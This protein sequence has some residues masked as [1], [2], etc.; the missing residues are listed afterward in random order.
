[1]PEENKD[2]MLNEFLPKVNGKSSVP[3]RLDD[4]NTNG[5]D[6]QIDEPQPINESG[7]A[8]SKRIADIIQKRQDFANQV[9][10]VYKHLSEL[11]EKIV[12]LKQ[13]R[14]ELVQK[15]G[16]TDVDKKLTEINFDILEERID[17]DIK[18][19][20]K[21]IQRF[22]RITLNIGVV[23]TMGQGKSE[24]LKSLS[25][26]TN[27]E[28]PAWKGKACTA[29]RSKVF[30]HD[31]ET[32]AIVKFHSETTF[33]KEVIG[34]YYRELNLGNIPTLD[35]FGSKPLPSLP[36]AKSATHQEMYN[37]LQNDYHLTFRHYH[38][39]LKTGSPREKII[40][41]KEDISKYVAQ[42][43]DEKKNL[44]NVEH[45][46]V[47]EVEIRCRFPKIEVNRLGLVD[48]PGLGDT[49][50]A[51]EKLI[52]KTLE[53]E[54]DI[55]LFV[56]KPDVDRYQWDKH[57]FNLY[58]IANEALDN[59]ASRA[60]MVL[61]YRKY[62]NEDNLSACE[63]LKNDTQS[64][65]IAEQ[66]IIADC[67]DRNETNKVLTKI[68]EYLDKNILEIE[69]QYARSRQNNVL[70]TYSY[71]NIELEK[72]QKALNSYVGKSQQ[73]ESNFEKTINA[74]STGLIDLLENLWENHEEI[75]VE[76]QK[77]IDDSIQKCNSDPGI[78]DAEQITELMRHP[79]YKN[80]NV[81]HRVLAAELRSHLSQNFLSLDQGLKD[82]SD[83]LKISI[84][85]TL[86]T[87][88]GL[89]ELAKSLDV[90]GI[91]FLEE[92][93]KM[94]NEH[95]NKLEVGFKTLLEFKM[96]Y[97]A[98]ILESIRRELEQVLGGVRANSQTQSSR[99][100]VIQSGT[101]A[102]KNVAVD[103]AVSVTQ[104]QLGLS[105][106]IVGEVVDVVS[107]VVNAGANDFKITDAASVKSD[108]E[109]LHTEAVERCRA[110]LEE[111]KKTPSRV[112][113]YMAEEFIDRV[114]YDK[115]MEREWRL[116]LSDP[117]ITSKVWIEFKQIEERKQIQVD[118][119]SAVK[120]VK[121]FNQRQRLVF[122]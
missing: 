50:V 38:N 8:I 109:R 31:G 28:L 103:V 6:T 71:I 114:L 122:V 5:L 35:D 57:D 16:S 99:E 82:A 53:Q 36:T 12:S 10:P 60:F 105:D 46:A 101:E 41:K 40:T 67:S 75:D 59:L 80:L 65:I 45:L 70:Q 97:G 43:R 32:K 119:I 4:P 94:L 18:E 98:L 89:G 22:S 86:I 48:V 56:R 104:A 74:L 55:V 58:D 44:I 83:Q 27:D 13:R 21:L 84:A 81:V 47:Q 79:R 3:Q 11:R 85:N 72:G 54:V 9:K 17:Q 87:K 23:G 49:R 7:N 20:D 66:P 116:F 39:S 64:I 19:L 29:V 61:N 51:D 112:R 92:M 25:G 117:D 26:L 2:S 52:L 1:M 42:K 76:F 34:E 78:P 102:I 90:N 15:I 100:E 107:N 88:G 118:W 69:E 121:E 33:I 113:Y 120:N 96:S 24:L 14:N 108:L 95:Q 30:H 110:T 73:F 37:R 106:S 68:L 77:V 91:K 63:D 111:W 115:G 93:S 62:G